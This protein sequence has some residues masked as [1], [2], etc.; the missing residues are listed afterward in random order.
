[1]YLPL[2]RDPGQ[3]VGTIGAGGSFGKQAML[4]RR[5]RSVNADVQ[6]MHMKLLSSIAQDLSRKLCYANQEIRSLNI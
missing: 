1:M 3:Q 5:S 2:G 4:E 6:V